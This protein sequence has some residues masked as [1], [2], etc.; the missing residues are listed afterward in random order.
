MV[1][2]NTQDEALMVHAFV[3][4]VLSGP[5]NDSLIRNRPRTF[6]EIRWRATAHIAAE[7]T[8]T[9][10]SGNVGVGKHKPRD[11]SRTQPMRVHETAT[12]KKSSMRRTPYK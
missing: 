4:G 2:L 7:E 12:E 5:F 6:G 10:K 8:V 1:E 11:E 3:R 9:T